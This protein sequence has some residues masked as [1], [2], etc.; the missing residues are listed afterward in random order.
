MGVISQNP[1]SQ[2]G[3]PRHTEVSNQIIQSHFK[4]SAFRSCCCC[5]ASQ[6]IVFLF[7]SKLLLDLSSSV[8]HVMS[9]VVYSSKRGETN[10]WFFDTFYSRNR[11]N[12]FVAEYPSLGYPTVPHVDTN[13]CSLSGQ[14][15]EESREVSFILQLGA[16]S[17]SCGGSWAWYQCMKREK[18]NAIKDRDGCKSRCI[19]W[20]LGDFLWASLSGKRSSPVQCTVGNLGGSDGHQ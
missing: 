1:V 3:H 11:D 13:F 12:D 2:T 19:T 18:P 8:A 20:E 17:E 15:T 16:I 9:R 14:I 5:E 7:P 10:Y 6:R 4:L